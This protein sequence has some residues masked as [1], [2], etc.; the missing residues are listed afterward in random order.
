MF[1]LYLPEGLLFEPT[2]DLLKYAGYKVDQK[3]SPNVRIENFNVQTKLLKP[4]D[5]PLLLCLGKA[6]LAL[7]GSEVVREFLLTYPKAAGRL[8]MILD[9]PIKNTTLV[10]AIARQ[11]F[12]LVT[13][14]PEFLT[15]FRKSG[16]TQI[17][18]A[19][20]F[21]ATTKSFLKK[22]GVTSAKFFS[23]AGLS[24]SWVLPPEPEADLTSEVIENP[25]ELEEAG[26]NIIEHIQENHAIVIANRSAIEDAY[27]KS[28]IDDFAKE[29]KRGLWR[30]K[31]S[32]ARLAGQL[33]LPTFRPQPA[34]SR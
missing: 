26:L 3:N 14:L 8:T 30:L 12:P 31:E 2:V 25:R 24:A 1:K 18:I 9:L 4:K 23:P 22:K 28:Q 5:A 34:W 17:V 6:D 16:Q 33:P 15:Q 11:R 21:P 10:L 29:L 13:S 20:Q 19:S 32:Q 7:V 27:R